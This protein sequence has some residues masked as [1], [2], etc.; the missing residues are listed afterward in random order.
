MSE[1]SPN[2]A[3]DDAIKKLMKDCEGSISTEQELSLKVKVEVLKAA[4][5]WEKLKHNI[6]DKDEEGTNWGGA[7]D[8][9]RA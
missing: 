4:M 8:E 9:E 3:I 2:K 7:P 5:T 1:K 6:R